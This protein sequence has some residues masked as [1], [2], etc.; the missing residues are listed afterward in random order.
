MAQLTALLRTDDAPM[1]YNQ[2]LEQIANI[3]NRII[4]LYEPWVDTGPKS[5]HETITQM[6]DKYVAHFG[7]PA[8]AEFKAEEAALLQ[9]WKDQA[10]G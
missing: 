9:Y 5:L 6:R 10:N 4:E 3:H 2:R 8:S 7:D 1:A